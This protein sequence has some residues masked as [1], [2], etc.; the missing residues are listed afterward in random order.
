MLYG[1][2]AALKPLTLVLFPAC[3]DYNQEAVSSAS[4]YI[5]SI[6]VFTVSFSWGGE[7]V[8]ISVVFDFS[9]V[10]NSKHI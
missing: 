1:I 10:F 8:S 7:A 6:L 4:S 2:Q 9:R 3:Q 5:F